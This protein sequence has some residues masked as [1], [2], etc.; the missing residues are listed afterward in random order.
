MTKNVDWDVKNQTKETKSPNLIS[1]SA[2]LLSWYLDS[3]MCILFAYFQDA[4][5]SDSIKCSFSSS[6]HDVDVHRRY[7]W[8]A[9]VSCDK[10]DDLWQFVEK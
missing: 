2:Y 6:Q 10:N 4:S 9:K 8:Q 5:Y 3:C 1:W 7:G